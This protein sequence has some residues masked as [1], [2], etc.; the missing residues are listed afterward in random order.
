M[1]RSTR[2][3]GGSAGGLAGRS[4]IGRFVAWRI[5]EPFG[6]HLRDSLF[7]ES[8]DGC[9]IRHFVRT[10]KR[11]RLAWAA[12]ASGS[13]DSMHVVLG[14]I[15]EFVVEDVPQLLD[16]ESPCSDVRRN[17][18]TR[19][20]RFEIGEGARSLRLTSVAV[21]WNGD[22][23]VLL[24]LLRESVRAMFR[25]CEDERLID[26]L[27]HKQV[28]EQV[29]LALFNRKVRF[30]SDEFA[31]HVSSCD[32]YEGGSIQ[33]SVR[34]R[35]D[36]VRKSRGEEQVLPFGRQQREY[37]S[38][39]SNESH[40]QHSIRLVQ[41]E[42]FDVAEIDGSLLYMVEQAT[43]SCDKNVYAAMQKLILRVD[44]DAPEN[45]PGG[46]RNVLAIGF[47][48]LFDLRREFASGGQNERANGS[49]RSG[50]SGR[51]DVEQLQHWQRESGCLARPGLRAGEDV[52]TLQNYGNRL[53]LN[54][55]RF[56]VT[57][58]SQGT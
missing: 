15:R 43:G 2:S 13:S 10:D 9:K 37:P 47:D 33:K 20:S 38:N 45:A 18:N 24:Q 42:D 16:V 19:G 46:E 49:S 6:F 1:H 31:L 26:F 52:S 44:I 50:V 5:A 40:V 28:N 32:F 22:D 4:H 21:D 25:A 35:F 27:F 11:D 23:A 51:T 30:L 53:R 34:K 56:G 57:R 58:L 55:R 14:N 41:N 54:R 7:N 3:R 17:Q 39:V 8:L 48:A 29:A 36:L 12:C